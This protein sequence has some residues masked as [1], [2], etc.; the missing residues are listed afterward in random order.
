MAAA[1]I[2]SWEDLGLQQGS[3]WLFRDL[4]LAIG[5]R[6]RLA[7]IG[8]NGAGKTTMLKLIAGGKKLSEIADTLALSPKTVSVY[9][10]RILEK[11]GQALLA[12]AIAA[13]RDVL[14]VG[15]G[16]RCRLRGNGAAGVE[17]DR[18]DW[19]LGSPP[20]TVW[21]ATAVRNMDR[22]LDPSPS[23]RG[24]CSGYHVQSARDIVLFRKCADTIQR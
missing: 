6:D 7:L 10:A 24:P 16:G 4:S 8:R 22:A 5:P 18:V 2:L 23:L 13:A 1:P 14:R 11:I 15:C 9:R 17:I 12:V 3:G 21:L 20:G 19:S